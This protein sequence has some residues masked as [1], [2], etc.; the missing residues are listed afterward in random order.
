MLEIPDEG[1]YHRL[2]SEYVA[3][4]KAGKSALVVSPTWREIQSVTVE[5]RAR[6]KAAGR[7]ASDED[8]IVAGR[9]LGVP[10]IVVSV[11]ATFF[12]SEALTATIIRR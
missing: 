11:F 2:A 7:V 1:R 12:G 6:L 10:L 5:I 9:T 8:Y 3:S 4:V